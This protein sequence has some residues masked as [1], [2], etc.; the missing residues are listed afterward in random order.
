MAGPWSF[1][2]RTRVGNTPG[3]WDP[4]DLI[5]DCPVIYAASER[6]QAL[7][8]MQDAGFRWLRQRFSWQVIESERG[9][10]DWTIWDEIV[11]DLAD[12]G[13]QLIAVLDS[14][15]AWARAAE[16]QGNA[17]APPAE[18]R[19]FG[20]FVEAFAAHYGDRID[21]YQV[22][23]EPNIAPH[24]GAREIDPAAYGRLLQEGTIRIRAADPGAII[25]TAALAPRR[26]EPI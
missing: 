9:V 18:T 5:P 17:L 15:P 24:W 8:A 26:A 10:Y 21:Y 3:Y 16:D 12:H 14:S 19:F 4:N 2:G 6:Q 7:T 20:D 1:V 13:L 23:D 25:L 11:G 22:W